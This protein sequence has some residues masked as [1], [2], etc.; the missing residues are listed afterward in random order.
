MKK[1]DETAE[2]DGSARE[3]QQRQ[4]KAK[5][6]GVRPAAKSSAQD[7]IDASLAR[8]KLKTSAARLS[9]WFFQS[10]IWLGCTSCCCASSASVLSPRTAASATLALNAAECVRR[11]L[12]LI[13]APVFTGEILAFRSSF[14]TYRIVQISGASSI[15]QPI[16]PSL[17]PDGIGLAEPPGSRAVRPEVVVVQPGLLV[18][19][20]SR[21]PEI[22]N[23]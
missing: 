10:V 16:P 6:G 7:A 9:N 14:H 4:T 13:F 8:L 22:E 12:L 18:R 1:N 19:I 23:E 11:G 3:P 17:Q 15:P 20:L 21:E 2:P 5:K